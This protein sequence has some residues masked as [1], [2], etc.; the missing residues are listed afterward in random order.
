M[1]GC[2]SVPEEY[3]YIAER[4]WSGKSRDGNE[5]SFYMNKYSCISATISTNCSSTKINGD[6]VCCWGDHSFR[7]CSCPCRSVEFSEP[8]NKQM[9]LK[10]AG[11]CGSDTYL[12]STFDLSPKETKEQKNKKFDEEMKKFDS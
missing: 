1:G 8:Q 12:V 7:T 3:W 5:I 10:Y 9:K 6:F 4:H 11:T 2:C